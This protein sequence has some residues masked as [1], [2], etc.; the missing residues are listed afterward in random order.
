[1]FLKSRS[2]G[3]HRFLCDA[4]GHTPIRRT[5]RSRGM[6]VTGGLECVIKPNG[7]LVTAARHSH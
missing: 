7:E 6:T 2:G 5:D 4:R 3:Y 1:M